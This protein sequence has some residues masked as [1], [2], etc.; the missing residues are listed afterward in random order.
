MSLS[1]T[2][3]KNIKVVDLK[4]V[5]PKISV[6]LNRLGIFSLFDLLFHL[7]FRYQ[8][9]TYISKVADLK[10]DNSTVLLCLKVNTIKGFVGS[11]GK[12]LKI[13]FE[14]ETGTIEA[15]FFNTYSTFVHNFTTGRRILAYGQV[16]PDFLTGRP[17]L[18][19]PEITF[20]HPNE[21]ITTEETLT[22]I[23]PS[24][25]GLSQAILRKTIKT[26][27]EIIKQSPLHEI[28]PQ[29]VN[30]YKESLNAALNNLHY[31]KPNAD[32]SQIIPQETA[33]FERICF[34]ELIAY[35]LCLLL[36]KSSNSNHNAAMSVPF[37]AAL[38]DAFLQS[39]PFKPT[40][41]QYRV[42]NEIMEDLNHPQ[43]MAR[44]VHGDVGSGKTLVALM[45]ALQVIKAGGQ[46][47]LLAPTEILARQHFAKC[48]H[49]LK[50][51]N[52]NCALLYSSQRKSERERALLQ[53]ADGSAQFIIGTHAVFQ[54]EVTYKNLALAI[55]DEQHRFGI[56]QRMALLRK[57]PAGTAAHQLVMTATPIPRTLQLALYSDLDVSTLD[58]LP[59]GRTPIV[60]ALIKDDRKDEVIARL[61][62]VCAQGTQAYWVCPHIEDNEEEIA[63]AKSVYE[64]LLK[65]LPQFTIGI[66]HGQMSTQQKNEVME[67]FARG[68]IRILVA[69]TIIEVGVDVPNASI[70]IINNAERLGLAQ[71]HQ[72]RGRV[73]RGAKQ[74]YCLLLHKADPDNIIA[75]KRLQIMRSSTDGFK[76]AQEDLLLRGPGE[77]IGTKQAGFD[78]F[79]VADVNR[80]HRLIESAR[81]AALDL[82]ENDKNAALE[83]IKRWFPNYLSPNS[84]TKNGNSVS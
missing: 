30:P 79:K 5:G 7:P 44:L 46:C 16:K 12:V 45:V 11:R 37:N 18:V 13:V 62:A 69:T 3:I 49:F 63:S 80:D 24:T 23:Y 48:L 58:E 72:L 26:A 83:L 29:H 41:A 57:A 1:D 25:E 28:L 61:K 21:E 78:A 54:K 32:H 2:Q 9:R 53:I 56:D 33:S 39:L 52:I 6:S 65:K 59:P 84:E 71:L 19:H 22:P 8:D 10:A 73:G 4:G 40:G 74:S 17:S 82:K 27:L 60:T 68:I 15:N 20:L 43:A 42:F 77:I 35:Q 66:I 38:N 31:P 50:N 34:E 14:D 47:V 67:S 64:D 76:I 36:L 81:N 55:I 75:Q 70:M 51:F